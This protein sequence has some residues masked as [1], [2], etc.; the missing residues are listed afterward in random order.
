MADKRQLPII[1]HSRRSFSEV[2]PL[3]KKHLSHSHFVQWHCANLERAQLIKVIGYFPNAYFS[4][5][6]LIYSSYQSGKLAVQNL[7]TLPLNRIVAETDTPYFNTPHRPSFPWDVENVLHRIAV[8][9]KMPIAIVANQ[10]TRNLNKLFNI[11]ISL[12]KY[13]REIRDR[14]RALSRKRRA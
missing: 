8:I 3:M 14:R 5:S 13:M 4:F 11:N 6:P 7:E 9:K 2:F 12:P 10:T 1:I